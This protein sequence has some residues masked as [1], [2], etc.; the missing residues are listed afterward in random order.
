MTVSML[1]NS[2]TLYVWW[3]LLLNPLVR[4][5]KEFARRKKI[6]GNVCSASLVL[7]QPHFPQFPDLFFSSVKRKEQSGFLKFILHAQK[8][9]K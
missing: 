8:K 2:N 4:K 1:T 9:E 7:N 3:Q 5:K 6:K